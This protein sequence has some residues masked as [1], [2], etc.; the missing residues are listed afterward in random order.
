MFGL[1]RDRLSSKTWAEI[2]ARYANLLVHCYK[3]RDVNGIQVSITALTHL[4]YSVNGVD[5]LDLKAKVARQFIDFV[6]READFPPEELPYV[7]WLVNHFFEI[8]QSRP[9]EYMLPW[10]QQLDD[11][12]LVRKQLKDACPDKNSTELTA[13]MLY[14]AKKQGQKSEA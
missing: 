13:M 9:A 7:E 1:N 3:K 14:Q 6:G 8:E 11:E 5:R 2:S 10:Y 4:C 12:W